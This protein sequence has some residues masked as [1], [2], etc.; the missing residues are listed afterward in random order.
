MT[1]YRDRAHPATHDHTDTLPAPARGFTVSTAAPTRSIAHVFAQRGP[2]GYTT[3][4]SIE[5]HTR[6]YPLATP[7][8]AAVSLL[9]QLGYTTAS[10]ITP[11][12]NHSAP[13]VSP[14]EP[15]W[16]RRERVRRDLAQTRLAPLFVGEGD[17]CQCVDFSHLGLRCEGHGYALGGIRSFNFTSKSFDNND[18]TCS[19][20]SR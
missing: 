20:H 12:Y 13:S 4:A 8:A 9:R 7:R 1:S 6:Q 14:A 10:T 15:F 17:E 3:R 2:N 16:E 19:S 18:S 11:S 5:N